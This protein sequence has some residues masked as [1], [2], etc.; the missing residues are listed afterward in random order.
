MSTRFGLLV[1]IWR[2][3]AICADYIV[4]PEEAEFAAR[5]FGMELWVG[6]IRSNC[7]SLAS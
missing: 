7:V 5:Q 1:F 6:K 2:R 4:F 3:R